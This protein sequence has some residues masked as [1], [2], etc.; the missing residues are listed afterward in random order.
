MKAFSIH[1]QNRDLRSK[2]D[3]E[4]WGTKRENERRE[5]VE[6]ARENETPYNILRLKCT[7]GRE[8]GKIHGLLDVGVITFLSIMLF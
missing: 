3:K 6:T 7:R 5:N 4:K 1:L 8:R 2:G